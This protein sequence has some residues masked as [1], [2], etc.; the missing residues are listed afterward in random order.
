MKITAFFT[1]RDVI[2]DILNGKY[3][4]FAEE[5]KT[6][7][8]GSNILL[9]DNKTNE[10]LALANL[11]DAFRITIDEFIERNHLDSDDE[12]IYERF[13]DTKLYGWRVKIEK[14]FDKPKVL[15]QYE[16]TYERLIDIDFDI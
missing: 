4:F 16:R 1:Y 2:D 11:K 7:L 5:Y 8:I 9:V 10:I 12:E 15:E 3:D 13:I 14:I 6:N